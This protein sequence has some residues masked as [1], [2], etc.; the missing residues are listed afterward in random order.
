MLLKNP[1]PAKKTNSH[2]WLN[3]H[4]F[5]DFILIWVACPNATQTTVPLLAESSSSS[6]RV[7]NKCAI[8]SY[9]EI[10][11]SPKRKHTNKYADNCFRI[12]QLKSRMN[13]SLSTTLQHITSHTSLCGSSNRILSNDQDLRKGRRPWA[14]FVSGLGIT[15]LR[16]GG[17]MRILD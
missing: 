13:T 5:A 8:H 11:Q 2:L 7:A 6:P 10:L 16:Y 15:S 17:L 12:T 4:Y 1:F 3:S 14:V 9:P